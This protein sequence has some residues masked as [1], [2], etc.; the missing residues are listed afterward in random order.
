LYGRNNYTWAVRTYTFSDRN[1]EPAFTASLQ[2]ANTIKPQA[3]AGG[4]SY[5]QPGLVHISWDDT[6]QSDRYISGYRIYRKSGALKAGSYTS[7]ETLRQAGFEPIE[8]TGIN[9][10]TGK[11]ILSGEW[12]YAVTS[13][14]I[15]GMESEVG[16]IQS[17][18][19]KAPYM[20]VPEQFSVRKTSKGISIEWDIVKQEG[21]KTYTIYK[22]SATETTA[23]KLSAVD[24]SKGVY[25]DANVKPGVLYYYSLSASGDYGTSAVSAEKFAKY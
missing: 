11:E 20:A 5:T 10:Y 4:R 21:V 19:A 9:E 6:K 25:I 2:V 23:T 3:P 12:Q 24:I 14:D 18:T 7:V 1:S 16:F 15:F 22:R 8:T 13:L 17:V